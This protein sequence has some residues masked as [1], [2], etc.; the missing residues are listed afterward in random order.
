MPE[1]VNLAE[2]LPPTG[3]LVAGPRARGRALLR[4][5]ALD[6]GLWARRVGPRVDALDRALPRLGVMVVGVYAPAGPTGIEEAV[7][8]L[9]RSR[10]D[11]RIVLGS[12]GEPRPAIADV[13]A[14]AGLG[15]GKFANLNRLLAA[16]PPGDADWLVA[17]DDDV[18]LPP[19]F[20]ERFLALAGR[21]DLSLA[22][23]ALRAASHTAW[24]I[25]RRRPRS[26]VRETSFVEIGPVTAL[27]HRTFAELLPFPAL[28]MGWGLDLHWAAVARRRGWKLGV[29]DATPVRHDL[30][31][32]A[33]SYEP[34]MA[35][36]EA[37]EFLASHPHLTYAEALAAGPV[38]RRL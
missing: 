38:Y 34:G 6:A 25:C 29:V 17:L 2:L 15:G 35:A 16:Q 5:A 23:P 30:R 8:A 19:R 24:D 32:T 22:Q 18:R 14:A 37:E 31:P 36:A 33:G 7:A 3:G 28:E 21:F 20:L 27:H 1:A 12:L 13:T 10:H 9:R 26:L 4:D 11:V